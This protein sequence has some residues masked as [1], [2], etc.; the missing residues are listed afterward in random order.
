MSQRSQHRT[1]QP[2]SGTSVAIGGEDR[3]LGSYRTMSSALQV[4]EY[5]TIRRGFRL[6][7]R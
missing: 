1:L 2:W 4:P 3:Y 6:F 7:S 5:P